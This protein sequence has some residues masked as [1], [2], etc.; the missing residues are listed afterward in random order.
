MPEDQYG[1]Y[2]TPMDAAM[3]RDNGPNHSSGLS[4]A[5]AATRRN[6]PQTSRELEDAKEALTR[7]AFDAAAPKLVLHSR[8][9]PKHGPDRETAEDKGQ[10]YAGLCNTTRCTSTNAVYWNCCTYGLYCLDC[11]TGINYH[12]A[13]PD[14]CVDHGKK[15]AT[16]E[17]MDALADAFS[18]EM[19][20]RRLW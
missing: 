3:G 7:A 16:I 10:V 19:R 11:A 9:Y 1:N 14:L 6:P 5:I 15:P 13:E 2:L 12:P 18:K 17:G 4:A 8:R 20:D